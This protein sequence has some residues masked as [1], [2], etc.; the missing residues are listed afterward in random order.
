LRRSPKHSGATVADMGRDFSTVGRALAAPARSAIVDA[1][2]DGSARPAGELAAV[3]GVG[4]S[5][6]SEHLAVLVDARLV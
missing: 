1:L 4:A 3:A 6:A 5:T 2:M